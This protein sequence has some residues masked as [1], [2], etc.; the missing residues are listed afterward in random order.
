MATVRYSIRQKKWIV[1][2]KSHG[3][4]LRHDCD[5]EQAALTFSQIQE[6]ISHK[7]ILL[8]APKRQRKSISVRELF[9]LH[10]LRCSKSSITIKQDMYHAKPLLD[11]FSRRS[12]LSITRAD[13]SAFCLIQ[14]QSGKAQSTI[15]RR[16][17]LL[18]S[19]MNWGWREGL[20]PEQIGRWTIPKGKNRRT[21]P[22]TI[23]EL[24]ALLHAASPHIRR[25]ILLGIYTGARVGPSELFSLTWDD[26][27]LAHGVISMPSA[28]KGGRLEKRDIPI[29]KEL[30]PLLTQWQRQDGDCPY[31]ISWA[32]KPVRKIGSA[33]KTAIRK[34]GIRPFRPYDLRHA[35]ATYAI[36]SGV[37]LKTSAEIMGHESARM[38]LDVYEHVDWTQKVKA[39]EAMPDFFGLSLSLPQNLPHKRNILKY[40]INDEGARQRVGNAVSVFH[41]GEDRSDSEIE[42]Q[43][44]HP[45]N[46]YAEHE[47]ETE[48]HY[49][50]VLQQHAKIKSGNKNNLSQQA[51]QKKLKQKVQNS[52]NARMFPQPKYPAD[53][54]DYPSK[55]RTDIHTTPPYTGAPFRDTPG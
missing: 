25:V 27:D 21:P 43:H 12:S 10:F 54:Q 52:Q 23:S 50:P 31:V 34:A 42:Q 36:R 22:P 29:R 5:S 38:I 33:W 8:R 3:A 28:N 4:S 45:A 19:I 55:S 11:F 7:E 30:L 26:V 15:H 44:D 2:W 39:I 13:I 37:D 16:I 46:E 53:E 9:D 49:P 32:G 6:T 14:K 51:K 48:Q 24:S 47:G 18:R 35:Y 17:S 1:T 20:L 41:D 40:E